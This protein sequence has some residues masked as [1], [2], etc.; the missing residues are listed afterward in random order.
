VEGNHET[1]TPALARSI[2][3]QDTKKRGTDPVFVVVVVIVLDETCHFQSSGL[4][5]QAVS[6]ALSTELLKGP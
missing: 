6:A 5:T 4:N 2:P 3:S 1:R